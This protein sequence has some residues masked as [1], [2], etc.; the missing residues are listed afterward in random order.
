MGITGMGVLFLLEILASFFRH[1][2]FEGFQ[3]SKKIYIYLGLKGVVEKRVGCFP[4]CLFLGGFFPLKIVKKICLC[5][6]I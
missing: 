3:I 5:D 2:E 6:K 1:N 4:V